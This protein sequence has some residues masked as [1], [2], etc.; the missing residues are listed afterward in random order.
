[1]IHNIAPK[2]SYSLANIISFSH[3]NND[4]FSEAGVE[5]SEDVEEAVVMVDEEGG[6]DVVVE[7]A[8]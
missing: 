7:G 1:M 4:N 6:V 3:T 8:Y 5:D 2:Y